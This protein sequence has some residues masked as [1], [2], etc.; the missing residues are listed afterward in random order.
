M[1][2]L[3]LALLAALTLTTLAAAGWVSR[4][5]A[6]PIVALT[7]FTRGFKHG[8]TR[9]IDP[10]AAAVKSASWGRHLVHLMQDIEQSQR[11]LVVAS[12][13]AASGNG[14]R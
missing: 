9:M 10:P 12:K 8:Q 2:L 13:L 14:L 3:S 5:I 11:K 6:R 1:A 7:E 4:A